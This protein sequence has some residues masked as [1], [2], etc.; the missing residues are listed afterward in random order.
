M[1]SPVP[2][3]Q[4]FLAGLAIPLENHKSAPSNDHPTT[5]G[6]SQE[7]ADHGNH[8]WSW[9][10]VLILENRWEKGES[11]PRQGCKEEWQFRTSLSMLADC[12][13]LREGLENKDGSERKRDRACHKQSGIYLANSNWVS[14]ALVGCLITGGFCWRVTGVGSKRHMR[15]CKKKCILF[16]NVFFESLIH[17][18]NYFGHIH[19]LLFRSDSSRTTPHPLLSTS[20][21]SITHWVW[22]VSTTVVLLVCEGTGVV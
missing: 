16:L 10:C 15:R 18:Y 22:L 21:F 2:A 9:V 8:T 17:A 4:Y 13:G 5:T 19:S 3:L 12:R 14:K 1:S 7:C 6:D 11:S 20:C